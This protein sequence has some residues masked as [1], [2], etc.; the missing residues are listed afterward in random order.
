MT[1]FDLIAAVIIVVSAFVGYSRG[2]V[3]EL[4]TVFAFAFAAMAAVYLLPYAGPLLGRMMGPPWA[5]NAAAV[6]IV[7]VLAYIALRLLGRYVTT[8]LHAQIAL[9]AVDSTIGLCFG[10]IRALLFLGVFYLVF[11]LATPPELLPQWIAKAKLYPLARAS[12]RVLGSVAPKTMTAGG[13]LGPALAKVV[14]NEDARTAPQPPPRRVVPSPA[15]TSRRNPA[16]AAPAYDKRTRDDI[17]ALIEK[18]R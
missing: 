18:T 3:R 9:G 16:P 12:A 4:V 13:R 8:K 7:F 1:L 15:Q 14:E 6:V 5:A 11:N 10:V 17:D 2:A